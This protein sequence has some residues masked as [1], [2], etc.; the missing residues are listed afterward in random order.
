MLN[1]LSR[2]PEFG[3]RHELNEGCGIPEIFCWTKMGA[4]AGQ[5]LETILQRKE[6]ERRAGCGTF[7][8]GI[9]NSLGTAANVARRVSPSGEV[10]VLFTPMKSAPKAIDAAPSQIM[11]WLGYYAGDNRVR[12]LPSHMLITSRGGADKRSHYALL[13]HSD[14]TIMDGGNGGTFDISEVQN[15]VSGNPIGASQ[16]TSIVQHRGGATS[17]QAKP[18][19]VAFRAKLHGEGFV[20]LASPVPLDD[21]MLALYKQVCRSVSVNEWRKGVQELRAIALSVTLAERDLF[22]AV[23]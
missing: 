4:E 6:L 23:A 18:Y 2:E 15:L 16:V 19:Q 1:A 7:A 13:C 22:A 3:F 9:G 12:G 11:V 5:P 21:A 8:W 14:S 20:R 10:D 17:H